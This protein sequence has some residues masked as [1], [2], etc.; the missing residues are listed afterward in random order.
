MAACPGNRS[1]RRMSTPKALEAVADVRLV[2]VAADA[3]VFVLKRFHELA[4]GHRRAVK[5]VGHGEA[6]EQDV[7]R[8]GVTDVGKLPNIGKR[9]CEGGV[10]AGRASHEKFCRPKS[11]PHETIGILDGLFRRRLGIGRAVLDES[12]DVVRQ[13]HRYGAA[14]NSREADAGRR[15]E[16]GESLGRRARR[17]V[18][19][20]RGRGIP[21]DLC[22]RDTRALQLL[23]GRCT[24]KEQR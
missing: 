13:E 15:V 9:Q 1:P 8:L 5:L 24:G 10:I 7:D 11:R 12:I 17:S 14:V 19:D 18:D 20:A 6:R 21:V 2:Q 4:V 3:G 16:L 22:D 23:G